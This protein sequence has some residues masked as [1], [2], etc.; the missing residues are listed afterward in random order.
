[1]E[2]K[3]FT[4]N[5]ISVNTYICWDNSGECVIIDPGCSNEKEEDLLESF[6]LDNNLKP[7]RLLYTHGHFDHTWGNQFASGR[8]NL[9]AELHES[10]TF[11]VEQS[12]QHAMMFGL[13]LPDAPKIELFLEEG[14]VIN[15]G[16]LSF[17]V[18]HVPGHSPGSLVFFEEKN[19][20]LFAGDV[21]FN[22]SVGR[23]DLPGGDH[24]T[25][26]SG[27]KEKL[28]TLPDNTTVYPG[29]GPETTIGI[30]KKINPFL[31]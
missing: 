6:I 29:H 21:L 9:K 14:D 11:L 23:T 5:P 28:L 20:A 4:F 2:I 16:D 19:E 13:D 30:E 31:Q 22:G 18:I 12:R 25:L 8:W 17:R 26:I 1:M 27:I 3:K 15:V 7:V 24:D 10:D